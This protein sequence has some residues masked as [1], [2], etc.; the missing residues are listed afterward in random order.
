[1]FI[2]VILAYV[3]IGLIELLPLYRKKHKK[4]FWVAAGITIVSLVIA[5]CLSLGVDI[6][7]PAT[8]IKNAINAISGK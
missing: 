6:P 4:D 2:L 3:F 7:S 1:M 5:V 8:P